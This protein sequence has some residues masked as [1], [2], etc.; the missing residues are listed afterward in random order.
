VITDKPEIICQQT[1]AELG[2][3]GEFSISLAMKIKKSVL[4]RL[5]K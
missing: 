5:Q 3:G 4:Q 2:V 1:G